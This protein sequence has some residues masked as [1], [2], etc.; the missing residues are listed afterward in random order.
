MNQKTD[1]NLIEMAVTGNEEALE[2]LVRR[3]YM[4]VYRLA[5]R[6][7]R[8]KEDAEDV[9][10]EVFVKMAGRLHSFRLK[11]SFPTWLYRVTVNT[12]MDLFRKRDV[13]GKYESM[14]ELPAITGNPSPNPE[15]AVLFRQIY[16]QL[17][18]LPA[19]QKAAVL[20]VFTEGLSHRDAARALGCS[21]TTIS[22]RIFQA[23]KKLSILTGRAH[24][25]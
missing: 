5:F 8:I 19:K 6:W 4:T 23:R 9:T 3:H 16:D 22:W 1:N 24:E 13:R 17:D 11:S 21:E 18:R 15:E 7:C 25:G 2:V 20:L 12:A 14:T 10:Q